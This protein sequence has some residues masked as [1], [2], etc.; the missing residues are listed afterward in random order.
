[1]TRPLALT[2]PV[3]AKEIATLLGVAEQTVQA[4]KHRGLLPSPRWP[5]VGGRPAWAWEQVRAWAIETG[6]A[7]VDLMLGQWSELVKIESMWT[8]I[9]AVAHQ[10]IQRAVP[11]VRP[12]FVG[13]LRAPLTLHSQDHNAT[14]VLGAQVYYM[15]TEDGGPAGW[16]GVAPDAAGWSSGQWLLS[17][18]VGTRGSPF[19]PAS[20]KEAAQKA[21]ASLVD[22]VTDATGET[23]QIG[24]LTVWTADGEEV[25]AS[26]YSGRVKP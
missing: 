24:E 9:L 8:P 17:E 13:M 22:A 11:E 7:S 21:V 2:D 15:P 10:V 12:Y 16:A 20:D 19:L 26:A 25:P 1:M 5:Q 3:G 18:R 4:W 23:P 14:P 6:R